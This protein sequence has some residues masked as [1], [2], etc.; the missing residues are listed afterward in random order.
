LKNDIIEVNLDIVNELFI[1]FLFLS[2][3]SYLV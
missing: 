2:L 3:R 1:D